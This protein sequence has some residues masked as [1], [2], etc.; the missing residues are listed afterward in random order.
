MAVEREVNLVSQIDKFILY[1]NLCVFSLIS[2]KG[3]APIFKE[4]KKSP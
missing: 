2:Q 1:H 3:N 4:D